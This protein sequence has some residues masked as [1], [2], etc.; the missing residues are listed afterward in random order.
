MGEVHNAVGIERDEEH[1]CI[2]VEVLQN[3]IIEIDEVSPSSRSSCNVSGS[4][5]GVGRYS[6]SLFRKKKGNNLFVLEFRQIYLLFWL[7]F[8]DSCCIHHIIGME[9]Q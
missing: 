8:F 9:N 4:S 1:N 6:E 7:W 2:E 5:T 3:Y